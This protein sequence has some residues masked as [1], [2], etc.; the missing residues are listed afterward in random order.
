M[1]NSSME[2]FSAV[3]ALHGLAVGAIP[4]LFRIATVR[5]E[6]HRVGNDDGPTAWVEPLSHLK[7]AIDYAAPAAS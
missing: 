3:S 5:G 7:S 2:K 6:S 4:Q 1:P